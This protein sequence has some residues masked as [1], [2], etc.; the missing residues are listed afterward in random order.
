MAKKSLFEKLG[1]VESEEP[2]RPESSGAIFMCNGVGDHYNNGDFPLDDPEPIQAEVPE[3]D[4]IDVQAVYAANDM[5][6]ADTVTVYKIKD[7]LDSLP[8]EMAN[9]TKKTTVKNL[10]GTLGYDTVAIQQDAQHRIDVLTAVANQKTTALNDE[11][12]ANSQQIEN[13]KI[14]IERLTARNNDAAQAINSTIDT[15]T[16]ER[17]NIE[18]VLEFIKDEPAGEESV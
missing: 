18:G 5:D 15:V 14:E 13:M 6:P 10:M 1:L 2:Q 9:K 12:T 16:A 17:H 11:I 3:G 7:M 4:T 8:P